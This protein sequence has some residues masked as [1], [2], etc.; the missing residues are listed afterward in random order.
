MKGLAL[1]LAAS[2][3]S[4]MAIADEP[5]PVPDG[6]LWFYAE[7]PCRD[8]ETGQEGHCYIGQ[9]NDGTVYMTFWQRD[10][11]QFIR[12]VLSRTEYEQVWTRATYAGA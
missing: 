8:N 1:T 4:T 11:L 7:A 10:E 3:S 5:P 6:G 2:L 12:K 9:A